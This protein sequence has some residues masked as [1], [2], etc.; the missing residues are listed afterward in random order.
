MARERVSQPSGSGANAASVSENSI[1]NGNNKSSESRP[2]V[3]DL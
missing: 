3:G 2:T 1:S